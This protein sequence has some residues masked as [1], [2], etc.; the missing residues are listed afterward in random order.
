MLDGS[1][2]TC[3]K[4]F[5][6]FCPRVAIG[7]WDPWRMGTPISKQAE[8]DIREARIIAHRPSGSIGNVEIQR[9][10]DETPGFLPPFL[11]GPATDSPKITAEEM[12][13]YLDEVD[14]TER[15]LPTE[16]KY[17]R[18]G[19]TRRILNPEALGPED[20]GRMCYI[21]SAAPPCST[22]FSIQRRTKKEPVTARLHYPPC[23]HC[24]KEIYGDR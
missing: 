21:E 8:K 4:Q 18:E 12:K 6:N 17:S 20:R 2:K 14:A 11:V 5:E 13:I 19:D 3:G 1:T 10:H 9:R 7:F 22:Q 16:A 24:N 23:S 15:R